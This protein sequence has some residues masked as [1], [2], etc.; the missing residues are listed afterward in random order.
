MVAFGLDSGLVAERDGLLRDLGSLRLDESLFSEHKLPQEFDDS[1]S[2]NQIGEPV[3][4]CELSNGSL[5]S[6]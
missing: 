3:Y 1:M 4:V 5:R 6:K 2:I